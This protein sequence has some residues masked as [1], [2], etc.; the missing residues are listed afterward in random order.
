[1][2]DTLRAS[3]LKTRREAVEEGLPTLLL[4]K[5]QEQ[6]REVRGKPL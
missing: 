5:R 1:M 6:I 2:R 3:G 4:L